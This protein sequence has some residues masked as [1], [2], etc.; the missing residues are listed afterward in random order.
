MGGRNSSAKAR[1]RRSLPDE[2][3]TPGELE[4]LLSK[5]LRDLLAGEL[6]PAVANA[7]AGL[8][9][10]LASIHETATLEARIAALEELSGLSGRRIA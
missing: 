2:A 9:R 8:G 3:L 7:A 5:A 6:A 10:A 1:L 4:A